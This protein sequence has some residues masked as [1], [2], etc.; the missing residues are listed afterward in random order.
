VVQLM[1]PLLQA[2]QHHVKIYGQKKVA[3]GYM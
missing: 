1:I 3:Q 2:R